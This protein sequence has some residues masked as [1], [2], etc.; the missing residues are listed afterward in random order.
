VR[1][2]V[3]AF[4]SGNLSQLSFS[5]QAITPASNAPNQANPRFGFELTIR[6]ARKAV[7]NN[8]TANGQLMIAIAKF[9]F[10]IL[11]LTFLY[12]VLFV[13]FSA[14]LIPR[15]AQTGGAEAHVFLALLTVSLLN[16]L[17]LAYVILRSGFTGWW[18]MLNVFLVFFGVATF[19][20]QIETAVFVR[21]LPPGLLAGIVYS[22]LLLALIFSC[23]AVVVLG[24]RAPNQNPEVRHV[25][26]SRNQWLMRLTLLAVCY[27]IIYFTF[28]YFVAWRN[29]AVRAFY[30]G[31]DPGTLFAQIRS[32]VRDTP[33]LPALQFV[34]GLIWTLL[35]LPLMRMIKGS[36]WEVGLAVALC[37][38]VLPSSQLLIPNPIM[39]TE[40]R[41][42]HLW[43]TAS[44]NFVFGWIVVVVL[45]RW[46]NSRPF[47]TKREPVRTN[48]RANPGW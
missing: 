36:W 1:R 7:G 19:L 4:D 39:P 18:L 16:S 48:E 46:R 21:N 40:V 35:A 41:A 17:V 2:L 37:F 26:L 44:S 43:E 38:C 30:Q 42:A 15:P 28:G 31:T 33:W 22:G 47:Q 11:V 45:L 32:V 14:I 29:P 20:P 9:V 27:V 25:S 34:R 13:T 24:K 10:R 23:L 12:L 8:S 6:S 3:G 5:K